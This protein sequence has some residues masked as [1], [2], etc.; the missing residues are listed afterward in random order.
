MCGTVQ[1]S[2]SKALIKQQELKGNVAKN[3]IKTLIARIPLIIIDLNVLLKPKMKFSLY[4]FLDFLLEHT[5]CI[6]DKNSSS[7]AFLVEKVVDF[8]TLPVCA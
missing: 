6:Q 4:I 5:L 2:R 8:D 3:K 7:V 1:E